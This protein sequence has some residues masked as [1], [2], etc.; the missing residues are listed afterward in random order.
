MRWVGY[1]IGILVLGLVLFRLLSL[2][3]FDCFEVGEMVILSGF[4]GWVV[5]NFKLFRYFI[6]K[7]V[8]GWYCGV[9]LRYFIIMCVFEI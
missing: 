9:F 4:D 3:V 7:V 6:G 1:L 5:L 8:M 2:L